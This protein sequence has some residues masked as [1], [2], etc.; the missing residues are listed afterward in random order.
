M[1]KQGIAF[2]MLLIAAGCASKKD[3]GPSTSD[4]WLEPSLPDK[5]ELSPTGRNPF[6]ILE[7]GYQL[8]LE[9]DGG[10]DRLLI[11]V[12]EDKKLVD[13]VETRV[14]EEYETEG[15]KVAEVSRNYFAISKKTGDVYYFGEDVDMYQNGKVTGHGGSWLAGVHGAKAGLMMP[16]KPAVGMRFY[17]EQAI[18]VA[19]DRCEIL[20]VSEK[21]STPAGKF[22]SCVKVAESTPL[23]AGK[24]EPKLYAPGVG[25]L[26]DG[27]FRL[28][29]YG[30]GIVSR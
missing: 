17:Q 10:K 28:V 24:P 11:T 4:G 19:M 8:L 29:K 14:V 20:S 26:A 15:G 13:G 2:V 23:E 1:I 6:F 5:R 18:G 12:L 3:A 7:P 27:E 22:A 30:K 25:L 9:N 21:V 16:G